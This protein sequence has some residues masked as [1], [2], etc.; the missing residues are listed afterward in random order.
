MGDALAYDPLIG[1]PLGQYLHDVQV[2]DGLAYLAY[3][4][5]GLVILD[6]GAGIEGGSPENP[7]FISQ[8]N[9]DVANLYPP[10]MLAGSHAVYRYKDYVFLADEVF[11]PLPD[12]SSR[13]RIKPSR[14]LAPP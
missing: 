2:V 1:F 8:L 11:P 7:K 12:L 4:R 13:G 6:V 9:Y 14:C 5:H 3:W 10:D